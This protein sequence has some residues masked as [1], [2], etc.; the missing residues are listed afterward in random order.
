MSEPKNLDDF[1]N[2][3]STEDEIR[4]LEECESGVTF[5]S[6][7]HEFQGVLE[8]LEMETFLGNVQ[9][10][11]G[12][13]G[14]EKYLC[15]AVD[16]VFAKMFFSRLETGELQLVCSHPDDSDEILRVFIKGPILNGLFKEI[17]KQLASRKEKK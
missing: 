16:K 2:I 6:L 14:S 1:D 17:K 8:D 12:G 3:Q 13:S 7:L 10:D 9:W 15:S 4:E 11:E 5:D